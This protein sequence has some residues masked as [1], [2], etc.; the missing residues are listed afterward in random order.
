MNKRYCTLKLVN[1]EKVQYNYKM[2]SGK[3]PSHTLKNLYCSLIRYRWHN[4]YLHAAHTFLVS[5]Y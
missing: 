1:K 4:F 3:L 5:I 2:D